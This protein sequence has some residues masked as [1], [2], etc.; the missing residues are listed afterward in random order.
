MIRF[1]MCFGKDFV[2]DNP[3]SHI[4][5]KRPVYIRLL[6]LCQNQGWDVYVV[7]K[8]HTKVM[9]FLTVCGYL[10]MGYLRD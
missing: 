9:E 1:G 8:K 4:T 3:L 10:Q 2:G 7:T 6:E 5:V